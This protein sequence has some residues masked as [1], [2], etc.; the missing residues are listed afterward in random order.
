MGTKKKL[1]KKCCGKFKKKGKHCSSCPIG[2][3]S[4]SCKPDKEYCKDCDIKDTKKDKGKKK[5]K[6]KAKSA[7]K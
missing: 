4:G 7:K 1:K 6:E 5:L 2:S 3:G